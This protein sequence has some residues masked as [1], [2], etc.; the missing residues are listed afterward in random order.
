M[1]CNRLKW[2]KIGVTSRQSSPRAM[3]GTVQAPKRRMTGMA[4][5]PASAGVPPERMS[6]ARKKA[7]QTRVKSA[8]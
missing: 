5:P 1:R 3:A 2:R 8:V 7:T 6:M 4:I